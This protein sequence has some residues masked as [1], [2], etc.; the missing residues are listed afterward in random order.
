MKKFIYS[1]AIALM[2]L[3]SCSQDDMPMMPGGDGSVTF[4]VTLDSEVQSRT[5]GDGLS[6]TTLQYAV[7]DDNENLVTNSSTTFESNSLST[8]VTIDLPASNSEYD[9]V[10]FAYHNMNGVYTFDAEAKTVTVNYTMMNNTSTFK[11]DYDCFY[12]KEHLSGSGSRSVTLNRAVAQVNF[13]TNDYDGT[14]GA[15]AN[16]YGSSL[17]TKFH[18]TANNTLNLLTG[19]LSNEVEFT[20]NSAVSPISSTYGTFPIDG[21]NYIY[22]IY[23]L[24]GDESS[25]V[26]GELIFHRSGTEKARLQITNLPIQRNY[27]TNV[28]GKLLT[29]TTDFEVTKDPMTA[30]EYNNEVWDGKPGV[31]P[32]LIDNTYTITTASQLAAVAKAVNDGNKMSG[33]TVKLAHDID[34][35][36]H[37][38]TPIGADYSKPFN[39]NFDGAGY[40]IKNLK[41]DRTGMSTVYAGLFGAVWNG[42]STFKDVTLDGVN[43]NVQNGSATA[44][45]TSAFIGTA[46][47]KVIDNVTIKNVNI[48]SYRQTGGIVGAVYGDVTN[49]TAEN[50]VIDLAMN[51]DKN[52][53]YD[54]GDKAGAIVGFDAEESGVF[55]GNKAT[56]VKI[57][58]FRDLGGLFGR[59]NKNTYKD[60]SITNVDIYQSLENALDQKADSKNFGAILG[61]NDSAVDGGNNTVVGYTFHAAIVDVDSQSTLAEALTQGGFV[62]IK[63]N[64]NITITETLTVNTPTTISIPEGATVSVGSNAIQNNSE[65]TINGGGSF[66]GSN[67]V[68]INEVGGSLVIEDGVFT[69]TANTH[70]AAAV[71]SSGDITINGGQFNALQGAAV[72]LNFM[73]NGQP[74]EGTAVINGGEFVNTKSGS[75]VLEVGGKCNLTINGGT[76]IGNFGCMRI[77]SN[78]GEVVIN[79]GTFICN[80]EDNSFYALALDPDTYSSGSSV[81]VNGGKFWALRANTLYC[82]SSK[83]STMVLKGGLYKNLSIG[84]TPATGY[85][86]ETVDL[87][88]TVT[89]NGITVNPKYT[90][91]ISK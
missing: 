87:S 81:T 34:L 57:T 61:R 36:N 63:E 29:S 12:K 24:A 28:Y 5:L 38:W 56:N 16:T 76:F 75:Y 70:S 43:I 18:A 51:K 37:N 86:S 22:C 90:V 35:D 11:R 10:F 47:V 26:D 67:F 89:A 14:N 55:S 8:T 72:T 48:K 78:K 25:L 82:S 91:K 73:K 13:G 2:G 53:N 6:A 27:R 31:L 80:G 41:I 60:N 65:L 40:T 46:N 7:Y 32:E 49:C 15:T 3:A 84:G 33:I 64:A 69:T 68:V 42:S 52:G 20:T 66:T 85:K 88:E 54:N 21:Y 79:D 1:A 45:A 19:E 58:G 9:V 30:G 4:T 62:A 17:R 44:S 83:K 39:G 59:I 23:L 71:H 77:D 50:I 74:N